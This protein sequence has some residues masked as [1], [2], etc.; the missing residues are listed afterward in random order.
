MLEGRALMLAALLAAGAA[1]SQTRPPAQQ[2]AAPPAARFN[3]TRFGEETFNSVCAGC[4]GTDLSGGRGPSLFDPKLLGA[5]SDQRLHDR[6]AA[7]IPGT[8]MP[9]FKGAYSDDQIYQIIAY[10]RLHAADMKGPPAFVPKPA[11]QVIRSQKQAFRIAVVTDK[12]ETP[13][14]LAFL[15]DG[16]LLVTERPGRLRI[17]DKSGKLLPDPVKNTPKV[18]ERQDG[19]M[20]DIAIH[21]DYRKNGLI[22]LSYAEMAPGHVLTKEEIGPPPPGERP[23]SPPSMTV[24][25]RGRINARNEWVTDKEIFRAPTALYT[26]SGAH[27]GSRF[28]FDGRGHVFFSLGER[29]DMTNAQKLDVPLGKI[30][31]VNDDGSVPADNPF[32]HTP[33][34]IPTIWSYGHRNPEGLAFDPATGIL[35]ESE[36]GPTGGDEINIIEKGHNYGWGVISMG[37]QPGIAKREAPGMDQPIVYYT[38]TLAPSGIHFYEG[39][40]Y[41]GWK[42]NL[43]VA[44]LAGQ[45]LL[46]LEIKGRTVAAQE[47]VFEQFGRVRASA[48]GPDGLLYVLLQNPTGPGSGVNLSASTPGTLVRLEP[49]P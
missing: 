5:R 49:L 48:T 20:F 28:L 19:G 42:G 25:I 43:F 10:L 35:W 41:P 39:T 47:T 7:G 2:T 38:P 3:P 45:K 15:P 24:L 17:I 34:A 36:H 16:R 13:W 37:I 40:R 26:A 9:A 32:V 27:Y 30:H 8:E 33:G 44:G 46:R 18:W 11:G 4:H 21:P 23:K 29:G 22:Y 12:L 6:I 1:V 31:R 14:G